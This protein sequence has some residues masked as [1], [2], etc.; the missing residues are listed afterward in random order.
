MF[1]TRT[2]MAN[3]LGI[4]VRTLRRRLKKL[5]IPLDRGFLCPKQQGMILEAFGLDPLDQKNLDYQEIN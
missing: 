1:K 5:Q 3:I 2:E 4:S